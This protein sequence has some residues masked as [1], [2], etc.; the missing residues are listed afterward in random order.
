MQAVST[1][2]GYVSIDTATYLCPH[3]RNVDTPCGVNCTC[4]VISLYQTCNL[5]RIGI[6]ADF[7]PEIPW[8]LHPLTP[9]CVCPKSQINVSYTIFP[10]TPVSDQRCSQCVTCT[11]TWATAELDPLHQLLSW[12]TLTSAEDLAFCGSWLGVSHKLLE[13]LFTCKL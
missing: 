2:Q 8:E 7:V 13:D 1:L 6:T 5:H 4:T 3:L 10:L 11:P 9:D 12:C